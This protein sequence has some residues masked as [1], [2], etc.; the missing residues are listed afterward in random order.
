MR[1]KLIAMTVAGGALFMGFGALPEQGLARG[2]AGFGGGGQ[3]GAGGSMTFGGAHIGGTNAGVPHLGGTN[4]GGFRAGAAPFG[5]AR[6]LG[7]SGPGFH[8][9]AAVEPLPFRGG[10]VS[11]DYFAEQSSAARQRFAANHALHV[12]TPEQSGSNLSVHH[13]RALSDNGI[14]SNRSRSAAG[15]HLPFSN[16][17]GRFWRG[18][19]FWPYALGG[20]L[21][22][23]YFPDN[24]YGSFWG[25]HADALLD[26]ALW[27][28]GDAAPGYTDGVAVIDGTGEDAS[29]ALG[30]SRVPSLNNL[31][32]TCNGFTPGVSDL[33]IQSL[34]RV[35]NGKPEQ[36]AALEDLKKAVGEAARF[37]RHSCLAQEP[38][39]PV[40]RLD[41]IKRRL[42]AMREAE[43]I[44]KGPLFRLYDLLS[45]FQKQRFEAA[46]KSWMAGAP[47][48]A[49]SNNASVEALCSSEEP[50][51]PLLPVDEIADTITL[52]E[53]QKRELEKFKDAAVRASEGLKAACPAAALDSIAARFGAAEARITALI[54]A[55]ETLRPA[56]V[57]FF[58]SLTDEQKAELNATQA[59]RQA[60]SKR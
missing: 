2:G 5:G 13:G 48:R 49:R 59:P 6:S 30:S 9:G 25:Y 55:V 31:A 40:A 53:A 1:L 37:L 28:Y 16:R 11:P 27:P 22:Y 14:F 39:T 21:S 17:H 4:F 44:V 56:A 52:D 20:T 32:V 57:G 36:Q 43:N 10:R 3:I 34:E 26:D 33:P 58:A 47:Q 8:A 18:A 7:G 46:A 54:Q 60:L 42:V 19:A 12:R 41:A 50:N 29:G 24:Y 35:V 51:Q 45:E 15:S 23:P 38:L